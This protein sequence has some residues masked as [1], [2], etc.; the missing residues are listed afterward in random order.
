MFFPGVKSMNTNPNR[1]EGSQSNRNFND[2]LQ[3][4]IKET[5]L[6]IFG[7]KSTK[8]IF[9]TMEKVHSIRLDDV[10]SKSHV[11]DV[12]LKDILGTGHQIV[13]DMI[14]E[15]LF[16]RTGKVFEYRENFSFSDYVNSIKDSSSMK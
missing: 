13:E 15:N 8:T 5:L 7:E 11:F 16:D 12:A 3:V 4:T 10:S 14:L 2:V 1:S 9:K 6:G